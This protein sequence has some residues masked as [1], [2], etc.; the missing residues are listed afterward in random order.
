MVGII[1]RTSPRHRWLR[2]TLA[3]PPGEE[4]MRCHF[5][6]GYDPS[7]SGLNVNTAATP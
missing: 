1:G 3:L 4:A 6:L 5:Q 7:T 2:D